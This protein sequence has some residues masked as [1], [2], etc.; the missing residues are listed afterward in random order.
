[1]NHSGNTTIL[2]LALEFISVLNADNELMPDA[3]LQFRQRQFNLRDTLQA[4]EIC[5]RYGSPSSIP[6]IQMMCFYGKEC[7]LQRVNSTVIALNL[8][9]ILDPGSVIA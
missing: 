7:S 2:Q 1:M 9:M 3:F 8:V 4:I 6:I 5:S